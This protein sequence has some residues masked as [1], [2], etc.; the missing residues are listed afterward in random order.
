ML[1][2]IIPFSFNEQHHS[3]HYINR[4]RDV[5]A[6]SQVHNVTGL[7]ADGM[8]QRALGPECYKHDDAAEKKE[9]KRTLCT[10]SIHVTYAHVWLKLQCNA[11]T[12]MHVH[13]HVHCTL[14]L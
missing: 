2:I 8:V 11:L 4:V 5:A 14:I 9:N 1:Y 13:V 12:C 3:L 6:V 10:V 7:A